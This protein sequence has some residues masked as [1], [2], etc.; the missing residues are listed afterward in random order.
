MNWWKRGSAATK[1]GYIRAASIPSVSI[2]KKR[3]GFFKQWHCDEQST[4]LLYVGRVSKE[5][6]LHLLSDAYRRLVESTPRVM[7]TVVGDGPYTG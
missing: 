1:S 6:N 5:K 7:L 4:K 2:R 3:N